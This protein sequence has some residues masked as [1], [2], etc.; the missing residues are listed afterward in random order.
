M[1]SS[2]VYVEY[3]EWSMLYSN[4]ATLSMCNTSCECSRDKRTGDEEQKCCN[5]IE[6]F[7]ANYTFDVLIGLCNNMKACKHIHSSIHLI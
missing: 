2:K 3:V 1:Q 6:Q 5:M 4:S 7:L